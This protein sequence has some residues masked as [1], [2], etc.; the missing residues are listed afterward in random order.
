MRELDLHLVKAVDTH[1]HADHITGLGAL[2]DRTH[3][4]TVMREQSSVERHPPARTCTTLTLRLHVHTH[5]RGSAI[6][7]SSASS[8]IEAAVPADTL[9]HAIEDN[10]ATHSPRGSG[11]PDS[12]W[13]A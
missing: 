1:L 8:T 5:A 4:I 7:S 6:G 9:V 3:C 11:E 2:R 12:C 10:Y 13:R